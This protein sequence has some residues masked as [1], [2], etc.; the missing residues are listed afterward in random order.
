MNVPV[1]RRCLERANDFNGD[2]SARI[3]RIDAN[4]A[5]L[6]A[7]I[8]G[9]S[10]HERRSQY[11]YAPRAFGELRGGK[12]RTL[13]YHVSKVRRMQALAVV[14]YDEQYAE[15]CRT[16]L[17]RWSDRHR[18]VFGTSGDS[19]M[20]RRALALTN[21]IGAPDL[22]GELILLDGHV[23]GF[24]F[25]GELRRGLGCLYEAKTDLSVPGLAHFQCYSFICKLNGCMLVNG[26]SDARRAGIGQLKDSL[27]PATMLLE[28]RG[29]QAAQS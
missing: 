1:A 16:L 20:S 19:G 7:S 25:G 23:V 12:Y 8:P 5:T 10:I 3:L 6:A 18:Q 21:A 9:L 26:G 17:D 15:A 4:D 11:L 22:V 29:I 2:R 14:P 27:R 24:A 28:Y 13:R